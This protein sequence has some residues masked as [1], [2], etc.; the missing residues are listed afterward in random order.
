M[1]K[2]LIFFCFSITCCNSTKTP[3]S[4]INK[5]FKE[6]D[7]IYVVKQKRVSTAY[8]GFKYP[9]IHINGYNGYSIEISNYQNFDN[10][11]E[12]KFNHTYSSFYTRQTMYEKFGDWD[13][14]ISI[15]GQRTPFLM[16]KNV[17][18]F[19]DE[20]KTYN[21]IAGG[22]ECTTCKSDDDRIYASVFILD[23]Y[24][25]DLLSDKNSKLT[26]KIVSFFSDG[27]KNLTNSVEF[28]NKFWKLAK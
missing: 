7:S 15:L 22:Y 23:E 2:I 3:S 20:D 14:V 16:W 6:P 25:N 1:K 26:Q 28:Y 17:K 9:Y 8:K 4:E 5:R 13:T 12:L 11:M 21:V 18:L 27:I 24:E 19:E 10:L